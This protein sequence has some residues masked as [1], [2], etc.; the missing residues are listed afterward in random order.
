M[1]IRG[2]GRPDY[3]S[4]DMKALVLKF[5]LF[6]EWSSFHTGSEI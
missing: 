2:F 3:V 1:M 6:D 4:V 5:K